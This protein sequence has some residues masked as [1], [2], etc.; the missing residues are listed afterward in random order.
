MN[1]YFNGAAYADFDNDG[2]LDIVIN[3]LNGPA[4]MLQN[5]TSVQNQLTVKFKGSGLNT[6]GIGSKVYL[7]Y[8][9]MVQY[10]QLMLTRGFQSA[11]EARMHFGLNTLNTVDSVLV[12][13]PD[14]RFQVIRNVPA[15]KILELS[16]ENSTGIFRYQ[17]WF[18]PEPAMVSNLKDLITWAHKEN[19]FDDFNVQYL[20]PH[21]QST[22]GPKIAV[23]DING[24]GLDDIF[25]CGAR[26]QAS[27]LFQ[28]LPNGSFISIDTALFVADKESEDVDALFFDAN[29][30]SHPDLYVVTGGNEID[31]RNSA[32]LDR[33]YLNN[34]KG[35]F[36]KTTDAIP[37]IFQ[38]KSCVTSADFDKDGDADL[39]V[40]VLA[41]ARA[42]GI[43]QTS[44][45]LLNDGKG[46]FTIGGSDRINLTNIGMVTAA[47]AG[48][49]D[50][51]GWPDL[52]V[53]R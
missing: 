45:L 30:D 12:V 1:G 26:G 10:Q 8:N 2:R 21:A 25:L 51:N 34:G 16:Q 24:D 36:I 18:K 47:A 5:L 35:H 4:V 15:N 20:L 40:G 28:Q 6:S 42:Y 32:L 48:D 46:R 44:Y 27:S 7:F 22:R 19:A 52:V 29:G 17:D 23:A 49:F 39:F 41:N 43:P 33:L 53:A 9:G 14:Q 50:K 3:Q 31:G 11:C 13:W 38:N 37:Q